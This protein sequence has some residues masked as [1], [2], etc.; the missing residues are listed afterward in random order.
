[1][2]PWGCYDSGAHVSPVTCEH[3]VL[4]LLS[5]AHPITHLFSG[6]VQTL[7]PLHWSALEVEAEE[8]T[9]ILPVLMQQRH[10][11]VER[12][13]QLSR[14]SLLPSMDCEHLAIRT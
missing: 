9:S 10:G 12:G 4:D 14:T 2:V 13:W 11:E 6:Q 5:H 8:G 1:M 3:F 7:S